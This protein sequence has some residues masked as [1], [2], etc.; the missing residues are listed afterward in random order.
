MED[1]AS[2]KQCLVM[3]EL[4]AQLAAVDPELARAYAAIDA[5]DTDG[6]A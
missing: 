1:D 5:G 6:E 4:A 2:V 3:V